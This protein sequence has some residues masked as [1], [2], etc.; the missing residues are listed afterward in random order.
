MPSRCA[1]TTAI[2]RVAASAVPAVPAV[3]AGGAAG[4]ATAA[5]GRGWPVAPSGTAAS[6]S[7][8]AAMAASAASRPASPRTVTPNGSPAAVSP[9]GTAMPARS[10]R[11]AKVVKRPSA[12][13]AAIGSARSASIVVVNGVVGTSSADT[14]GERR[15]RLAAQ[16]AQ[17]VVAAEHLD[18]RDLG[19]APT[20]RRARRGARRRDAPRG[21]PR[22]RRSARRA[23]GRRR[24]SRPCAGTA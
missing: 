3:E 23:T 9:T 1:P 12:A 17:E 18:A 6:C 16:D 7:T 13:F 22:G 4:G 8:E 5:G 24:A 21:T 14:L 19:A 10:S 2:G 20:P 15:L 11:F